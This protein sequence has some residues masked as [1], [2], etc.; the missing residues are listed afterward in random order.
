M[1]KLDELFAESGRA[2]GSKHSTRL[3]E[4]RH[5]GRNGAQGVRGVTSNP[6]IFAKTLATSTAYDELLEARP[7]ST[8]KCSS[9]SS[10]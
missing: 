5:V 8:S 6:S 3:V 10:P 1:T 4:R 2:P 7:T 9:K